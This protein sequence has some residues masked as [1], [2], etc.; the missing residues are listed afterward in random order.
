MSRTI[1]YPLIIPPATPVYAVVM[2][3]SSLYN[4]IG[5]NFDAKATYTGLTDWTP[6]ALA[7]ADVSA[8][9]D[10]HIY[11]A[12]LPDSLP[13]G[14]YLI[15]VRARI[16]ASPADS[17]S[18]LGFF[19]HTVLAVAEEVDDDDI[20]IINPLIGLLTDDEWRV[21]MNE[22]KQISVDNQSVTEHSLPEL[23]MVDKYTA[24]RKVG[25]LAGGGWGHVMKARAV[26][27]AATGD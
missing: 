18:I 8:D 17:D 5:S 6:Y 20:T 7:M 23:L 12:T 3:G 14:N 16:G 2:D 11:T 26:P 1:T 19:T 15:I 13:A 4:L 24:N 10:S 9:D 27:P 25:N 22:A 21:K